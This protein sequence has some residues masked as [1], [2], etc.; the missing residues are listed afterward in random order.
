[1]KRRRESHQRNERP[2]IARVHEPMDIDMTIKKT[3]E[4]KCYSCRKV[5]HIARNCFS[6]KK[7]F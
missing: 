2:Q 7:D 6:G 4:Q 5:G 3:Q 1:M